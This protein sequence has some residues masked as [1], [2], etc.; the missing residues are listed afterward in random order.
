MSIDVGVRMF[1]VIV[2]AGALGACARNPLASPADQCRS[3]TD[4][5][6][7]DL[8]RADPKNPAAAV[9]IA[10]AAAL[11]SAAT[12]HRQFDKFPNCIDTAERARNLL[13]PYAK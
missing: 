7:E 6:Y 11:L 13:K 1:A 5:A 3:L 10:R 8:Q 12:V 4:A 2:V 9:D